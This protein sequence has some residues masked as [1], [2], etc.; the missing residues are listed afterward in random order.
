MKISFIDMLR[1]A[2]EQGEKK[3]EKYTAHF[4]VGVDL[5]DDGA[6][7]GS[8]TV[9]RGTPFETVGMVDLLIKNL[10]DIKKDIL[11]KLSTKEQKRTR[12]NMSELIESL[13][14]GVREKVLDLKKRMDAAV[15]SNDTEALKELQKEVLNLKN[16]F[17]HSDDD[18]DDDDNFNINDFKGG[19]A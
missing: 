7:H 11:N 9:S 13:P 17:E 18:D 16:P 6:P 8:L 2:Q 5:S 4:I 12:H 3:G 19:M 10:Q 1:E 14:K 15:E